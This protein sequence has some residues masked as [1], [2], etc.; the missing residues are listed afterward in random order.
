MSSQHAPVNLHGL[1]SSD[2]ERTTITGFPIQAFGNDGVCELF[3][4]HAKVSIYT[5]N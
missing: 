3:L 4:F 2:F 5:L 1:G